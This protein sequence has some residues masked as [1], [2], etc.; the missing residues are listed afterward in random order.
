MTEFLWNWRAAAQRILL[1]EHGT[2]WERRFCRRLLMSWKGPV[3]TSRQ[4]AVLR[5]I[6]KK[7]QEAA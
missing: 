2:P 5:K 1:T 4:E 7:T 3:L 6:Y